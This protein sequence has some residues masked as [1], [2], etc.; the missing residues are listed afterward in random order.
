MIGIKIK[1]EYYKKGSEVKGCLKILILKKIKVYSRNF[2]SQDDDEEEEERD[3][4]EK[5][6][7]VKKIFNLAKP[8]MNDLLDYLKTALESVKIKIAENH[9]VFGLDSYAD[10]GKYIGIIWGILSVVNSMHEKLKISAEPSFA[11]SV[12]DA[13]GVN[14]VDIYPLK[15]VVPTIKLV[16]KK[17]IRTLI[18]G[19]LDER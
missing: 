15:L 14:E 13:K 10:T 7:D 17:E 4:E 1:L 6:R 2:P 11:G 18:R 16:S 19:V 5:E 8:C 9:L 12:L 3:D